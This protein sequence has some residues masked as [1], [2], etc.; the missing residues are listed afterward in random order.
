MVAFVAAS[1]LSAANLNA[2]FNQLTVN[3]QTGTTYTF[4]LTDQGGLVTLANAAAITLTVPPNASVAYAT[5][6]QIALMQ[7]GAGQVTITPGAG[8]TINSYGS[9]LKI[10]GQGGLAVL[11]KTGTNT[12]QA[13]GALTI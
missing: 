9:A 6:T 1:V 2:A 3:A 5:G 4:V 10:V 7:T 11:V 13:A 8:V 12:W